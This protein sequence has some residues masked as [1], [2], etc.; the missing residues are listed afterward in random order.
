MVD[1]ELL[2]DWQL[3]EDMFEERAAILEFDAGYSCYEA[4]QLAAQM[5]GFA[6]KSEL[7]HHVQLLK[8]KDIN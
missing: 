4:E 6:N 8:S 2:N 3:L 1:Q 7:K 5:Y